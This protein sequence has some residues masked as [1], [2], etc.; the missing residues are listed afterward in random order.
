VRVPSPEDEGRRQL[1]RELESLKKERG[2]HKKRI[3]SLLF[4]QG[5]AVDVTAALVGTLESMR[6]ADGRALPTE[7]VTRIRREG[8]RL[9]RVEEQLRVAEAE[10]RARVKEGADVGAVR[11]RT[12]IGPSTQSDSATIDVRVES[13]SSRSP[14][15]C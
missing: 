12:L 3:Q 7:L 1:D 8:E 10:R 5:I 2:V 6:T 4:A 11:M 14:D 9:A 15:V 13:A